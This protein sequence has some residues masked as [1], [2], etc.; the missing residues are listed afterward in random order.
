MKTIKASEGTPYDAPKHFN[1]VSVKK[2]TSE[3]S[4]RTSVSLSTFQ[5]NGGTAMAASDAE[6]VYYVI[7]GSIRVRGKAEEHVLSPGDILYIA[8]GEEREIAV[9][10]G[11]P[12]NIL[13]I[14]VT[15]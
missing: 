6:R 15:P 12:A 2:V 3:F 9:N 11:Q 13:V 5:S 10:G 4:R 14:V 1:M 8:P 7:S